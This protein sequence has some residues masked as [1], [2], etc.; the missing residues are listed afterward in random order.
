MFLSDGELSGGQLF[1]TGA[2]LGV[3]AHLTYFIHGERNNSSVRIFRSITGGAFFVFVL[4]LTTNKTIFKGL[5]RGLI[6]NFGFLI[7]LTS[8][9]IVYRLFFHRLRKFPGPRIDAISKCPA[10]GYAYSTGHYFKRLQ[11]LHDTYGDYVRT[12]LFSLSRLLTLD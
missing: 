3:S 5:L 1:L 10:A 2:A 11:E 9:I 8:S 6:P 12:G 4:A 7:G